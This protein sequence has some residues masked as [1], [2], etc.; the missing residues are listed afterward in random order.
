MKIAIVTEYYYPSLGGITEHVHNFYSELKKRGHHP[1]IITGDAGVDSNIDMREI[2]IIRIGKS[3]PIYS[4]GSIARVSASFDMGRRVKEIIKSEQF[5]IIHIHSPLTPYLPVLV[6]RYA[7]TLTVGTFHTHFDSCFFL[8]TFSRVMKKYFDAFAGRIAVSKLCIESMSRYFEGGFKIIPNGVDVSKFRGGHEKIESFADGRINIFFLGRLEPRNGL[9]YL[10][11][12]FVDIR[13]KRSDCRLII[14][15]DGPLKKYF[16]SLV[17]S[18]LKNDIHFVGRLNGLRPNYYSTC[19]IFCFPTTKA[20]FG[21]TLL[22]AMASE[23]PVVA[24]SLPAYNGFVNSGKNGILCGK[25]SI[26]NLADSINELLDSPEK[27]KI[28]GANARITA[29]KFSWVSIATEVLNYYEEIKN[30]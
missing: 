23:K 15:G 25:A 14:G 16:E 13:S 10:I 22:E 2:N 11:R 26:K 30:N 18:S 24:F 6:Q 20:S 8:R 19:D 1:V 17:P 4:N 28:F 5:D 7:N 21:I 3:V 12:A 9:E 27:R 29:E